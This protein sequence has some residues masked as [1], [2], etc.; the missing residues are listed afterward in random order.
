MNASRPQPQPSV[1]PT[2]SNAPSWLLFVLVLAAI[3][4]IGYYAFYDTGRE[5]DA[6][7]P[8]Q[9]VSLTSPSPVPVATATPAPSPSPSP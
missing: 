9:V 7:K 5:A 4:G 3:G 2:G 6:G 1:P 8:P